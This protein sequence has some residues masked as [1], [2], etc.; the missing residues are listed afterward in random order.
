VRVGQHLAQLDRSHLLTVLSTQE[1]YATAFIDYFSSVNF[2]ILQNIK[3]IGK[4]LY[5]G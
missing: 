3:G 2:N 5:T 1:L 4:R